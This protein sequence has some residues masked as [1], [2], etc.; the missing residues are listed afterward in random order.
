MA[1]ETK[2][3]QRGYLLRICSVRISYRGRVAWDALLAEGRRLMACLD[4]MSR[5]CPGTESC[6][7]GLECR[8]PFDPQ[9]EFAMV[10]DTILFPGLLQ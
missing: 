6:P 8:R 3:R 2:V 5:V 1:D 7:R 10:R 4:L 9:R